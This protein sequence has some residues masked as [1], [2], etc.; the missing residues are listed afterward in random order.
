[1]LSN[2]ARQFI[3][4]SN[5]GRKFEIANRTMMLTPNQTVCIQPFQG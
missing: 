5:D 4:Q 3:V 1:M 2:M